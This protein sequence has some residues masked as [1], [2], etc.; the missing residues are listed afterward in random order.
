LGLTHSNQA[1]PAIVIFSRSVPFPVAL[2][3]SIS[4]AC[5]PA[6]FA[7]TDGRIHWKPVAGAH[8]KLDGKPPLAWNVYQPEKSQKKN[9][10]VLILLGHRY[11][12]IDMKAKIV[13]QVLLS[14]LEAQGE[15]FETG[16][17]FTQERLLPTDSWTVR[18]VGP[19]ELIKVTLKDYGRELEVFLPHPPD[20]RKFY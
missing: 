13:Y 4:L 19:A 2:L 14:D 8:V 6:S 3:L 7:A 11:L 10:L 9:N 15:D 18:D 20:M 12:G 5:L 1:A 16:D 17:V